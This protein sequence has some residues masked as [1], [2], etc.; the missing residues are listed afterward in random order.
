MNLERKV[1]PNGAVL[2]AVA[3]N[4]SPA[5]H[6]RCLLSAGAAFDGGHTGLACLAARLLDGGTER[7]SRS[8]IY[9]ELDSLGATL[10]IAESR[11]TVCLD[12]HFLAEDFPRVVNVLRDILVS[13]TFPVEELERQRAALVTSILADAQDTQ[14]VCENRLQAEIFP[15]GHP[16][17]HPIKGFVES[18]KAIARDDVVSF[19]RAFHSP[20]RSIFALSGD[21]EA[22]EALARLEAA[23][24]RVAEKSECP[25]VAFPAPEALGEPVKVT[26][27]LADKSQADIAFGHR[28]LRRSDPDYYPFLVMNHALGGTGVGGRL[29][30]EI[31]EKRGLAYYVY[32]SFAAGVGAGAFQVRA[33]VNPAGVDAAV[34][35][36]LGEL[37]RVA[38]E[39]VTEAEVEESKQYLIGSL[40]RQVET[41]AGIVRHLAEAE[42][43]QLGADYL[44]RFPEL[45]GGVSVSDCRRVAGSRLEPDHGVL[46]IAGPCEAGSGSALPE[47]LTR[48]V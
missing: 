3:N 5:A 46:V 25:E 31:R 27:T 14:A 1:L 9:E 8:E 10:E 15:P 23:M 7:R 21:L 42:R 18:V 22:G 45:V 34:E 38:A 43:L 24:S 11:E 20:Q 37:R 16:Y 28:A 6:L 2:L 29:G 47:R 35:C 4:V 40:P 26:A 12:A 41:H 48:T 19:S 44:E 36:I 13:P 30:M 33:G 39:G 17:H 32:S